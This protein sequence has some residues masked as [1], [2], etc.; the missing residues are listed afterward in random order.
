ML[1]T[2]TVSIIAL[3][4][5]GLPVDSLDAQQVVGRSDRVFTT[6][7]PVGSGGEVRLF[8]SVG[9]I[10][11]TEGSGSTVEFRAEK[12]TRRGNVEDAGFIVLRE[13]DGVT[14]CAVFDDD[15][16]C[17][18]DGLRSDSRSRWNRNWRDRVRLTMTVTVP[19]G[20]R[21]HTSSGNGDVSVQAAVAEARVRSG[22]GK[23]RISDVT[24]SVDA[25]SGNGEVS[26]EKVGGSVRARS[27]NGDVMIGTTN[28]PVNASSGNGDVRVTM[29]RLTGNEDMEFTS[30]NGRIEVSVPADF[31]A[32]VEANTGNG[33]ITT[34][35]PITIQGKL[36]RNRLRGTIGN[37]GRRLR[38]STGNGSMEIR[39][40]G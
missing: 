13:G 35:F 23:V 17:D 10:T 18:R 24:G 6:S 32:D 36:T 20:A 34:D 4:C 28:G 7:A 40:R 5:I 2:V 33:R 39:K 12:D 9:D 38:M 30:G 27:G 22:N 26:V 15:D 14:I 3:A 37:G 8:A 19:R 1:R 31:S 25:S 29:D 16:R 11:I 21:L